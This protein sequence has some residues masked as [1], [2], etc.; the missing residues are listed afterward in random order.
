M[1]VEAADGGSGGGCGGGG[2]CRRRRR[3]AKGAAHLLQ[4]I[5]LGQCQPCQ[6]AAE[7]F[8]L[9]LVGHWQR[10]EFQAEQQEAAIDLLHLLLI[11]WKLELGIYT[12]ECCET[13]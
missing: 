6:H 9:L 11:Y 3:G 13:F 10:D 1:R 12:E 2:G 5:I 7:A 4:A 8:K